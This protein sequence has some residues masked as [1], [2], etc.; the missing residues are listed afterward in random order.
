MNHL[1]HF[2]L[3]PA[4]DAGRAGTLLG[5]FVRGSDLSAWP[6]GV[7]FGIRLHRRIDAFT[8]THPVLSEARGALPAPLRRYAG[9]LMDVYFDHLLIAQ[10]DEWHTQPL[11]DFADE[12]H[13]AL[14]RLAPTL[15]APADRVASGMAAH[16]GLLACATDT[17]MTRILARIGGRL[18]RPLALEEALPSVMAAHAPLEAAFRRFFPALKAQAAA[19]RGGSTLSTRPSELSV[20]R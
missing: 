11:G 4:D 8:D 18:S 6:A 3:A 14:A 5:D 12:V 19:Y 1:A 9:I 2:L 10:W 16:K 7:E 15:P 20:S 13:G 17:G